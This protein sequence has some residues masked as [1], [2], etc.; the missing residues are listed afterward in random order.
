[1]PP[2]AEVP[3]SV[4]AEADQ[5]GNA[6]APPEPEAAVAEP[7]AE[8][9]TRAEADA[10]LTVRDDDAE[11]APPVNEAPAVPPTVEASG[12]EV[13]VDGTAESEQPAPARTPE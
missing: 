3:A 2:P 10:A 11:A 6:P 4:P 1:P 13:Q 8:L 12:T 5:A 9:P 7:V